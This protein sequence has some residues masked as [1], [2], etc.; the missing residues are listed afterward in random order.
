MELI[1]QND[2]RFPYL[3]KEIPLAPE[4]IYVRGKLPEE[5]KIHVAIVGTRK[6]SQ[7]S[8]D[9]AFKF[10]KVLAENGVVVVSGLA[11]GIDAAAHKGCLAGDG[12]TVA[13]LAG[14][15]DSIYPAENKLLA[16]SILEN[17]GALIS[18]YPPK[19]DSLKAYFVARN[20]IVSGLCKATL[21][22]EV[23]Q[24]SGAKATARF[25]LE[26]NR[27]V[28]VVP[29]PASNANFTHSHDLIRQGATLVY[30]PNQLL[31]AIGIQPV[32]SPK[33]KLIKTNNLPPES[34]SILNVLSHAQFP[35]SI[36]KITELTKL[37]TRAA[38]QLLTHLR[39]DHYINEN[40]EGY[41]LSN[42]T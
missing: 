1:P 14:G 9:I 8:S 23:P 2:A 4:A 34:Q 27:D 42:T 20:R 10:G 31:E 35:L 24:K 40:D 5:S 33:K 28:F 21:L 41:F 29:G 16:N 7:S 26:Q 13:V 38:C 17:D 39:L 22:I 37:N 18:E 15:L 25:A 3:L 11:F 6:C 32:I 19:T 12:Q 36:D 30:E